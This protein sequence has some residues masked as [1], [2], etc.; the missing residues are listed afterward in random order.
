MT[1]TAGPRATL[2]SFS[3]IDGAGK[4]T[5]IQKA[6]ERLTSAGLSVRI[7]TFWDDVAQLRV[8]REEVGHK[9]FRGDR[10][11]G[12]PN[13]PIV[14]RDKNVRSPLV[15]LFR[16]GVYVLDA[17][18]LRFKAEKARRSGTDVIIFDRFLYDELANLDLTRPAVRLYVRLLLQIAPK[19][20]LALLLDA[21]P[22]EAFARKPEYPLD[23]LHANRNAYLRLAQVAGCMT[24]VPPLPVDAASEM[25]ASA[26]WSVTAGRLGAHTG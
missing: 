1:G 23:F 24:V 14:R 21:N 18:S 13:A 16:L 7:I 22:A 10:G 9:V 4:S 12:T 20:H 26:V 15:T 6:C 19:P 11:V 25:V 8:L 2:I 17:I 5:Q 3:G